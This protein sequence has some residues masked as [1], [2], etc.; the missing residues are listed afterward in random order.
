MLGKHSSKER[1][2]MITS[3][4]LDHIDLPKGI[5]WYEVDG[6]KLFPI[7]SA[8]VPDIVAYLYEPE[9]KYTFGLIFTPREQTN[10]TLAK[11]KINE[12][13]KSFMEK[14]NGFEKD[15]EKVLE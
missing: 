6:K 1:F 5:Y 14:I 13:I 11:V 3:N 7:H 10:L 12:A 9:R 15:L 2:L 4:W 8:S